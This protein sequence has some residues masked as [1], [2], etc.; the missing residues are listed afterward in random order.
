MIHNHLRVLIQMVKAKGYGYHGASF[1]ARA[2]DEPPATRDFRIEVFYGESYSTQTEYLTIR[3]ASWNP[4]NE[5]ASIE[6]FL[7]LAAEQVGE[8][9]SLQEH[10]RKKLVNLLEEAAALAEDD[11]GE[12]ADLVGAMLRDTVE[13][14]SSNILKG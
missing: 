11:T 5:A 8:I 1:C 12:I 14:L 3:P 2:S 9:P 4:D 13:K 6:D 7:V 10:K